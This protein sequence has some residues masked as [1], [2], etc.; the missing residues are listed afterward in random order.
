MV[1]EPETVSAE[2]YTQPV[3]AAFR[4]CEDPTDGAG[5]MWQNSYVESGDRKVLYAAYEVQPDATQLVLISDSSGKIALDI[6]AATAAGRTPE[7]TA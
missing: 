7:P 2:G 3:E 1:S 5:A 6:P 4:W